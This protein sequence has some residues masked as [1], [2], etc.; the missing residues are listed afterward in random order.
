LGTG[1]LS[2]EAPASGEE[3]A[4]LLRR[5]AEQGARVR[6]VGG[7]TKI[8][9]G[10]PGDAVDVELSTGG[11]SGLLEHN[12][13][14]LTAV[15]G[16]GTPLAEAQARF[17]DAGQML[18]LDPPLGAGDAAT[19]GGVIAAGDSGPLRQRYGAPRDLVLG[20]TMALSDGTI[21]R[22]GGKVIKNVAGYDLAKLVAGSHG[23]LG[24]I[25]DVAVRLH[26]L[27]RTRATMRRDTSDADELGRVALL[28]SHSHLEM[29][30]LDVR[31]EGGTGSVFARFG[32]A[33]AHD[34]AKAAAEIAGGGEIVE[35]DAPLWQAQ[36]D[37]QR[38]ALVVRVSGLQAELPRAAR[39]AER[40]GAALSGR[41]AL[42]IW[43]LRWDSA[44]G[45]DVEELRARLTPFHCVVQ[46]APAELRERIDVWGEADAGR[47]ALARRV[48]ERFD[49][50]RTL[51]PG[52]FVGG[53]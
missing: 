28:L 11:L 20:M 17:A 41:G 30:S 53:I 38:G 29:E 8:D 4:E 44:D 6:P 34:Q 14:D 51:R 33:A 3:A 27:P 13:G 31:W 37:A 42:G 9:W 45:A 47:L 21:A 19:I 10:L 48:K 2:R 7:G 23:T 5:C 39:E 26:P 25:L 22:S 49:P 43:W 15:L 40:A 16:A 24:L 36:R 32:G 1:T 35:D 18:A 52:T 50:S 12:E 46:D